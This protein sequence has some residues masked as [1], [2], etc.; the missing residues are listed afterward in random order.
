MECL[1]I[2]IEQMNNNL[3]KQE[4]A[5]KE[6]EFRRATLELDNMQLKEQLENQRLKA[7]AGAKEESGSAAGQGGLGMREHMHYVFTILIIFLCFA[8]VAKNKH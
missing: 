5:H 1:Q 4:L 8:M 6:N 3:L 7:S 2:R